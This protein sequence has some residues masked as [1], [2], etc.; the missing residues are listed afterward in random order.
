MHILKSLISH[1][2]KENIKETRGGSR[3]FLRGGGALHIYT[4][5][6][7]GRFGGYGIYHKGKEGLEAIPRKNF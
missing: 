7:T 1:A 3:V 5:M 2:E 6:V 4:G